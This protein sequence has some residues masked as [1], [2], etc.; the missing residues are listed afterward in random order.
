M[1]TAGWKELTSWQRRIPSDSLE[2]RE[3]IGRESKLNII[4]IILEGSI[5]NSPGS[6]FLI[7]NLLHSIDDYSIGRCSRG[8][9]LHSIH[10]TWSSHYR[11]RHRR[12]F[13]SIRSIVIVDCRSDGIGTR[14][15]WGTERGDGLLHWWRWFTRINTTLITARPFLLIPFSPSLTLDCWCC[16]S[17]YSVV[18]QVQL[19]QQRDRPNDSTKKEL[20]CTSYHFYSCFIALS[21]QRKTHQNSVFFFI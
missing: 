21:I 8:C 6:T 4:L 15:S 13:R 11:W 17:H 14:R 9:S 19:L 10:S 18:Q 16:C 2:E 7:D 1:Q 3:A 20:V 12:W 5:N